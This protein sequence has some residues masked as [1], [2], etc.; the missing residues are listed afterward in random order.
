[1]VTR[2]MELRSSKSNVVEDAKETKEEQVQILK[3]DKVKMRN[4]MYWMIVILF[5]FVAYH[6][7]DVYKEHLKAQDIEQKEGMDCLYQFKTQECNP[8]KLS[9][10]CTELLTCIQKSANDVNEMEM[11]TQMLKRTSQSL[12][13]TV[14]GPTALIFG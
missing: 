10:K 14:L 8:M 5:A 7:H 6:S 12:S 13:E 11:M 2:R 1:M 4:S 3:T 9:Q